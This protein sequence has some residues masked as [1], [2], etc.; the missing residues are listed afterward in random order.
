MPARTGFPLKASMIGAPS[1]STRSGTRTRAFASRRRSRTR[2]R[3]DRVEPSDI[4]LVRHRNGWLRAR[5]THR[6]DLTSASRW[7]CS[8]VRRDECW[9]PLPA[10]ISRA[11]GGAPR[12]R[13]RRASSSS[14]PPR[15]SSLRPPR[16]DR[17]CSATRLALQ[18]RAPLQLGSSYPEHPAVRT[19]SP[20][21]C[22]ANSVAQV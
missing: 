2:W 4:V 17:L 22:G 21:L 6:H 9:R 3:V 15:C 16:S 7:A 11:T 18:P 13:A 20:P 10:A 14:N 5:S 1:L 19:R 8:R 12:R